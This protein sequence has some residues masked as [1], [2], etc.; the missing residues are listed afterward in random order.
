MPRRRAA[1]AV[2]NGPGHAG[3]ARCLRTLV[4][5]SAPWPDHHQ[6]IERRS[7]NAPGR[8][9]IL[10]AAVHRLQHRG[11]I[12]SFSGISEEQPRGKVL[13]AHAGGPEAAGRTQSPLGRFVRAIDRIMSPAP[14]R[15]SR[16][17]GMNWRRFIQR[18][19]EDAEQQQE[20]ER[21]SRSQPRSTSQAWNRMRHPAPHG[22]SSA[23]PHESGRRSSR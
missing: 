22:A 12:A 13:G 5:G 17:Y 8:T 3:H 2:R 7:K 18:A 11:W 19:Q 6:A 10:S 4:F 16:K 23:I 20:L 9:R 1:L 14:G 21:S 15:L